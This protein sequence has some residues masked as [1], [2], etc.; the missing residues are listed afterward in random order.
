MRLEDIAGVK[1]FKSWGDYFGYVGD[2]LAKMHDSALKEDAV[3]PKRPDFSEKRPD[4]TPPR[5][6]F[7]APE[8]AA[9]DA[10]RTLS[11]IMSDMRSNVS[12]K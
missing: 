11:G 5:Y 6:S 12:P 4:F 8:G 1:T 9:P 10:A 7:D 3:T 2:N